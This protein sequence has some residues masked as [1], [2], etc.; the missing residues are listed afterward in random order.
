MTNPKL[1]KRI[2][3]ISFCLF[4]IAMAVILIVFPERLMGAF[5]LLTGTVCGVL[6]FAATSHLYSQI[7]KQKT[8]GQMVL[9]SLL[10]ILA[11]LAAAAV[12]FVTVRLSSHMFFWCDVTGLLLVP[13]GTN[14]F[15]LAEVTGIIHT[16]YYV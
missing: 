6:I 5:G 10:L 16:N 1:E 7:G 3:Q 15:V 14:L 11:F 13:A 12:L 4:C 8:G 9:P 2:L